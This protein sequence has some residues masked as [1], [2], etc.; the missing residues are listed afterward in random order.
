MGRAL[1]GEELAQNILATPWPI[2]NFGGSDVDWTDLI[3]EADP[4]AKVTIKHSPS[5]PTGS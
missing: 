1:T 2:S 4:G 5:S 3:K